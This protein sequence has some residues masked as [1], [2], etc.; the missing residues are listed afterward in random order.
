MNIINWLFCRLGKHELKYNYL[1]FGAHLG[2]YC[3]RKECWTKPT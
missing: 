3:I 1:D 2:S